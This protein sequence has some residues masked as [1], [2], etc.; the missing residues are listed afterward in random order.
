MPCNNELD[1]KIATTQWIW[2]NLR[3]SLEVT[4]TGLLSST[5]IITAYKYTN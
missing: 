5:N 1:K 4:V 2:A 3:K